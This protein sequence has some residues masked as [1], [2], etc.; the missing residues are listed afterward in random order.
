MISI[1]GISRG[2]TRTIGLPYDTSIAAQVRLVVVDLGTTA[3]GVRAGALPY[4][5][6]IAAQVRLIVVDL[7]ATPR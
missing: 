6:S 4:D 1:T 3:P 2:G 7:G 5:P